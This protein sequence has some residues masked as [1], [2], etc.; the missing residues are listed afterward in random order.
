MPITCVQAGDNLLFV[1]DDGTVSAPLTIPSSITMSIVKPARFVAVD[2]YLVL[3]NTPS[4]PLLIDSTG[5]VRLLVPRPPRLAPTVAT[6]AGGTLTGTYNRIRYTFIV[7]DAN[8]NIISE[9]DYSPA[10]GSVSPVNQYI[11][12]SGIDIS[13]DEISGRRIYRPTS[14]GAVLFQWVDLDG[15]IIQTIQDDLPDA[16]LSLVGSPILGNPPYLTHIASFRGRLFGVA[17]DD[18]DHIRYTEA[19]IRYAWPAENVIEI[20]PRGADS[21]GITALVGRREALGVGRLNQLAQITG[22]GAEGT[23]G[24]PDFDNVILS[25]ELGILS[26]ESVAVYRDTAYFLWYDGIY[27]WNSEGIENIAEKGGVDKWFNTDSYFN[28]DR[29]EHAF[30]S[31]DPTRTKYRICLAEAGTT[32]ENTWVE[33]DIKDGT[34]WGPHKTNA[35]DPSSMVF[36]S[37]PTGR[38][39]LSFGSTQGD[40]NIEQ[41][42]RTDGTATAIEMDV[43]GKRHD[44][45]APD[46]DKYF[47]EL[48]MIGKAQTAGTLTIT[49]RTGELDQTTSTT[50]S[51]TMTNSRQRISRIGAGKHT[52]LEFT[53]SE[54]GQDVELYGYVIDPVHILGRR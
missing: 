21:V 27:K 26:Q 23:D 52:E 18:I 43:I 8:G 48:S 35:F 40:L 10:S 37:L 34:W 45:G 50:K 32:E 24:I 7:F 25:K 16:S 2:G 53:N 17:G 22:T 28:R 33:Y 19:G 41:D 14:N 3:V 30:A 12:V 5:K 1:S 29:Y 15:N 9:S 11:R 46:D 38:P 39:E 42:T 47:G 54:V 4:S 51:Y 13:P 6:A 36:V 20:Q 31:V 44:G 49:C